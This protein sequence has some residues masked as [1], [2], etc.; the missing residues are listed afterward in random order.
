MTSEGQKVEGTIPF[1]DPDQ[2]ELS[3]KIGKDILAM[4]TEVQGR[5]KA[6]KVLYDQVND[7][8]EEEEKEYRELEKKYEKLYSEVYQKRAQLINGEIAVDEA[9]V[10]AFDKRHE[11]LKD[12]KYKE[13]EVEVCDVKDI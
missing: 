3:F 8:D 1:S 2:A 12:D 13:L 5:F 11:E 10:E 9:L 6:L 7:L 4:P